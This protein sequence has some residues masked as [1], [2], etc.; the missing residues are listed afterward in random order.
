MVDR[1]ESQVRPPHLAAR[2]P[3]PIE[4]LRARHLVDQVPVDV[5]QRRLV[6]LL[7]HVAIPHFLKQR[8]THRPST[9]VIRDFRD[10][11]LATNTTRLAHEGVRTRLRTPTATFRFAR[12]FY[13]GRGS[14]PPRPR[15]SK[16]PTVNGR[17][18]VSP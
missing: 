10:A 8:L 5:K 3:K 14:P 11:E 15:P 16:F 6:G 18:P 1:R 12:A 2:Q 4:S 17:S 7:D 13:A 9:S